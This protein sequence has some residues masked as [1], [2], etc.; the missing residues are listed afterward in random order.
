MA[1]TVLFLDIDGVCHPLDASRISSLGKLEGDGLFRWAPHLMKLLDELPH[2]QVVVHSS[3]RQL[4][5]TDDEVRALMPPALGARVAA[6]TPREA[7]G[8]LE[9]ILAYVDREG[10]EQ[11]AIVDDDDGLFP[12]GLPELVLCSPTK[13]LSERAVIQA[14]RELLMVDVSDISFDPPRAVIGAK[15][16]DL[17]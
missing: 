10:V 4:F 13:G 16:V 3:W 2:V 12:E 1:K 17:S 11:F 14:L 8:R 5:E 9:S 6:C 15:P 7:L